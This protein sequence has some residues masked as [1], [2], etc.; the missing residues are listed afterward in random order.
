MPTNIVT[1]VLT[2]I[3]QVFNAINNVFGAKNTPE[4]KDRQTHQKEVNYQ[5]EVE[6]AVKDKDVKKIRDML[7]E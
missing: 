7:S 6:K 4:M 1:A 3:S 2:A 5:S